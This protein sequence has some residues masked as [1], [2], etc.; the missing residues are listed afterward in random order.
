MSGN[1]LKWKSDFEKY[2]IQTNFEK[3]AWQKA[4]FDDDWNFFWASV[5]TVK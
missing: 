1:K 4:T 5:W 2:V 3:R